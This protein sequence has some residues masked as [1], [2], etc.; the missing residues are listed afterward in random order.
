M[1]HYLIYSQADQQTLRVPEA[2]DAFHGVVAPGTV[3]GYFP[4]ATASFILTSRRPYFIDLK[5]PLF[6]D[7]LKEPRPSHISLA[8]QLSARLGEQVENLASL[9]PEFY[10]DDVLEELVQGSISFQREYAHRGQRLG[11]KLDRYARLRAEARGENVPEDAAEGLL[12]PELVL[13]PYFCANRGH[14]QRWLTITE[15]IWQLLLA[16]PNSAQLSPVVAVDSTDPHELGAML[17]RLPAGLSATVPY[18]L[19][20]FDERLESADSLHELWNVI[21]QWADT[22]QLINLYGSY[23]SI[24][25][26]KAGLHGFSNGIGFSESRK[27]PE[28]ASSGA[29]P[30]RYYVPRLHAFLPPAEAQLL[31]DAEPWFACP[32]PVCGQATNEGR[33]AVVAMSFHEIKL[34][35]VLARKLELD[36]VASHGLAAIYE[37]L[38]EAATRVV[39]LREAV[40]P[41]PSRLPS[42]HLEAWKDAL[43]RRL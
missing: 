36:F 6:Q 2:D 20:G 18:W 27:W 14:G 12:S 8:H 33:P 34:H 5:T 10:T 30:A 22:Y 37:Q 23:Y 32:C 1:R 4:D 16:M 39:R 38:D 41:I 40:L 26:Q 31:L 7:E 13:A 3:I 24:I 28:L 19:T 42:A 29:A 25:L 17:G 15:K 9:A 35:F 43:G 11:A 21:E